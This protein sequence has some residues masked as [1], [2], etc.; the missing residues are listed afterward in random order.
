MKLHS[1]HADSENIST[2]M[3]TSEMHKA[4]I[5]LKPHNPQPH[6]QPLKGNPYSGIVIVCEYLSFM[7]YLPFWLVVPV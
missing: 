2:Y 1:N 4:H 5:R 7:L 3:R 6:G